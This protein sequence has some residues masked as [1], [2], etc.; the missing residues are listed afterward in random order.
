MLYC[1]WCLLLNK[2]TGA[3]PATRSV[4]CIW[5]PEPEPYIGQLL[6]TQWAP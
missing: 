1:H 5:E 4:T 6:Y 3:T 2:C